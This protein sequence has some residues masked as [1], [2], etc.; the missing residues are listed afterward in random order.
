MIYA[1][2]RLSNHRTDLLRV[3]FNDERLVYIDLPNNIANASCRDAAIREWV[4]ETFKNV[5]FLGIDIDVDRKNLKNIMCI[6]VYPETHDAYNIYIP[7]L[8]SVKDQLPDE[9][10]EEIDKFLERVNHVSQWVNE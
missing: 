6:R 10:V 8:R 9:T 5:H 2:V 4:G 7:G 3:E 1:I